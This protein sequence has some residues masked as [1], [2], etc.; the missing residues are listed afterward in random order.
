MEEYDIRNEYELHNL[1]KKYLDNRFIEEL[2]IEFLKMP[3]LKFGN[4]DRQ[5]QVEE[6]LFSHAPIENNL[7]AE[8]YEE[9]F[10][11]RANTVLANFFDCIKVYMINKVYTVSNIDISPEQIEKTK[12]LLVEDF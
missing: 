10:G 2:Q 7:L 6:L 11:V 12:N 5:R 4:C 9:K 8:K 3:I 1:L